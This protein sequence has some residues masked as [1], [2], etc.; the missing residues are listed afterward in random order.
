MNFTDLQTW[1]ALGAVFTAVVTS[2][3]CAVTYMLYVAT[4]R[5]AVISRETARHQTEN[6][7]LEMLN[8]SNE[9]ILGDDR[10]LEIADRLYAHGPIDHSPD[11]ARQRW[12]AFVLLNIHELR[13]FKCRAGH[14]S[15]ELW[16]AKSER[17]LDRLLSQPKI[18]NLIENRGYHPE[19]VAHC[20]VRL[21][22]IQRNTS[23]AVPE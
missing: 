17:L 10:N 22:A 1:S 19:F 23:Q 7:L 14:V 11:A 18:I 5:L 20:R 15:S 3:L 16:T 8:F 2:A 21:R 13:Y 12:I 9:L 4:E 6:Q